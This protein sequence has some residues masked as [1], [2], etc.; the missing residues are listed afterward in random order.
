MNDV[1][2]PSGYL[3]GIDSGNTVIKAAVFDLNGNELAC[4]SEKMQTL[5]PQSGFTETDMQGHWGHCVEA[6]RAALADSGVRAD[7]VLAVGCSGHGNG[8]YLLD[9]QNQ[10]LLAIQSLDA[11]AE[12]LVSDDV[13]D[14]AAIRAIN[15]QGTWAAQTP[16]LLRWLKQNQP[17]TYSQIGTA[18][19][20]KDYIS[21]R[22][23]G[24]RCSDL[25]DMSGCGLIDFSHRHYSNELHALFGIADASGYLPELNN[26][27]DVI[28]GVT[29]QAAGETGLKSGTPVVAGL[30]DVVASAVGSGVER[31][32]RASIIAGTWSI[33]QVVVD[34]LPAPGS[35]FM[36]SCF[37]RERFFAIESSATSAT[38]LEW[39]VR[40]FCHPESIEAERRGLSVYEVCNE[41]LVSV[42]PLID[43]PLFHPYLYGSGQS[44]L[45]RAGFFGV[46]GWHGRREMLYALYEGV[47]FG[48]R[49]HIERLRAA[50]IEFESAILTGGGARSEYWAQMFADILNLEVH[51][52]AC[53]ETGAKG[54]A[55]AAGIG[56]GVFRDYADGVAAMTTVTR[57]FKPDHQRQT[58]YQQRYRLFCRLLA[59]MEPLWHAFANPTT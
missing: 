54:A 43:L 52:S 25:T 33:N 12:S 20:C 45:G 58:I 29:Q 11:R 37:D 27:S 19:L 23:S 32:G 10:P 4:H 39:F 31:T 42:E 30:F 57:T 15:H 40:E 48:H 41:Q 6:I 28:G 3:L 53:S 51:L 47:V 14:I 18:F 5:R 8:L 24:Q 2:K 36:A 34:A 46:T 13:L 38:N 35:I 50:G 44:S 49:H 16:L 56:A 7:E 1:Q 22:L 21:F 55:I 9:R 26:S 59:A 17:E